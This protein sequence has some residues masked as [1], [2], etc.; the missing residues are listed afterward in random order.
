MR[1]WRKQS[2]AISDAGGFLRMTLTGS[3]RGYYRS[4]VISLERQ[5]HII[6]TV[7][8]DGSVSVSSLSRRFAVSESTIRRDLQVL[9]RNG[10][11]VRT[12]GGAVSSGP[13]PGPAAP[14][15]P[16]PVEVPF[17]MGSAA[18]LDLKQRVACAGAGL[19]ADGEVVL[20]DI[21]TTTA[22]VARELRGRDVT[23]ITSNLGVLDE[24]RGD[25]AVR[26]VLL[27]GVVRRNYQTLVGSLTIG[28]LEQ[29]SADVA[30]LSCTGVRTNGRV[31]DNMAVEVPI[32][33]SLVEAADRV[34]L[35]ATEA[36]FPGTGSLRVCSLTDVD[37]LV[38]TT[39]ADS[40]TLAI[41]RDAG[42]KVVV[43]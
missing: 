16:P 7:L 23:V 24:L 34:V 6:R 40:S 8:A 2:R 27:G 14:G 15:N 21:G 10:E 42:R 19:V 39:G 17:Q 30:F 32:K 5:R 13:L 25:D 31:V 35:L 41:C 3:A 33:K 36:K 18:D 38:T 12:H 4:C 26:L 20:L 11:L 22:L 1:S 37:V 9:D 28:A 29:V 43:A